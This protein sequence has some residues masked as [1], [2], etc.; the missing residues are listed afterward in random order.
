MSS[1]DITK[2]KTYAGIIND[3]LYNSNSDQTACP[4]NLQQILKNGNSSGGLSINATGGTIICSQLNTNTIN[5]LQPTINQ[6]IY[7]NGNL[8]VSGNLDLSVGKYINYDGEIDIRQKN[9]SNIYTLN[10]NVY[11]DGSNINLNVFGSGKI[12]S[13]TTITTNGFIKYGGTNLQYL[14]AD[15]SVTSFSGNNGNSNIFLYKNVTTNLS[16]PPGNGGIKYNNAVQDNATIIYISHLTRDAIDIDV[17]L[18]QINIISVLYIQDQTDSDNFIYYDVSGT[19]ILMPNNYIS[20]P[21]FKTLSGGT[22][23]TSFGSDTNI[24]LSVLTNQLEVNNRITILEQ[25]TQNQT[26]IINST[27]FSGSITADTIIKNGGTSTQ[28]LKAN[29]TVSQVENHIIFNASS[30]STPSANTYYFG[31]LN[32]NPP[33]LTPNVPRVQFISPYSGT[34]SICNI[35]SYMTVGGNNGNIIFSIRNDS[36][37]TVSQINA[38][39]FNFSAPAIQ[40][41]TLATPLTVTK[42]NLLS[43]QFVSGNQVNLSGLQLQVTAIITVN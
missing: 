37:A 20:V 32:E 18:S 15:G 23:A 30:I 42:G 22:G 3:I 38:T 8:D 21:V 9:I 43:I 13:N 41:Y 11:I 1:S 25:K 16:P 33:S 31:S 36:T 24:I 27:T 34:I 12:L 5:P 39:N 4:P 6:K 10:N 29:G 40:S 14:M 26:A 19:P 17:F 28:F 7:I 35:Q 2:L